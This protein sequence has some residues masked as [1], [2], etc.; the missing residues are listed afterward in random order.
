MKQILQIIGAKVVDAGVVEITCIPFTS[1]EVREKR[2]SMLSMA[3]KGINIQD[4]VKEVQGERQRFSVFY[5]SQ[6]E[7]INVFKNQL[8]SSID[9]DI[10]INKKL[11]D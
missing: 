1:G 8:Y 11:G 9:V 6:D 7:W 10:N 3:M 2:K 4:M 5:I